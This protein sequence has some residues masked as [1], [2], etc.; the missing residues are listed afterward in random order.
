MM[1]SKPSSDTTNIAWLT[2]AMIASIMVMENVI[3]T[4]EPNTFTTQATA[5]R[6]RGSGQLKI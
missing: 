3:T 1:W 2:L 4:L 6:E 5:S